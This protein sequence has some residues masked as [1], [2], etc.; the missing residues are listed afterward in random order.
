[1]THPSICQPYFGS[2]NRVFTKLDANAGFWQIKLSEES[3]LYTT[4]ITPFG[5]FCFKRLPFRITSAP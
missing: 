2:A 4:F 5:K 1:M 3:A